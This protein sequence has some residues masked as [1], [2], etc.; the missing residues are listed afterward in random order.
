M[1]TYSSL[2]LNSDFRFDGDSGS[3][4]EMTTQLRDNVSPLTPPLRMARVTPVDN[5][6]EIELPPL[7]PPPGDQ[8][9]I[10]TKINVL[11]KKKVEIT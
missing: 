7:P 9:V 3:D 5:T 11:S 8:V 2:K 10:S 1:A 4:I 6:S